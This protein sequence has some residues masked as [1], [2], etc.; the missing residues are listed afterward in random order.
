MGLTDSVCEDQMDEYYIF[1]NGVFSMYCIFVFSPQSA[2]LRS[3]ASFIRLLVFF[4]ALLFFFFTLFLFT[5]FL[6]LFFNTL[7]IS[8]WQLLVERSVILE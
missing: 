1:Y 6:L 7:N 5:F 3:I 2:R 8:K 4:F